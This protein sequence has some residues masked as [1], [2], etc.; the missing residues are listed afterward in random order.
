MQ[1]RTDL[2]V[3]REWTALQSPSTRPTLFGKAESGIEK[4]LSS[5]PPFASN[6]ARLIS[7]LSSLPLPLFFYLSFFPQKVSVL[8]LVVLLALKLP[9]NSSWLRFQRKTRKWTCW[10]MLLIW[11]RRLSSILLPPMIW[12][13]R[14]RSLPLARNFPIIWERWDLSWSIGMWHGE[15]GFN[16]KLFIFLFLQMEGLLFPCQIVDNTPPPPEQPKPA[17]AAPTQS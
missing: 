3:T 14:K 2:S 10:D 9:I 5:P 8:E 16:P 13:R 15:R 6:I 1:Q 17:A 4:S 12:K 7:F 11:L